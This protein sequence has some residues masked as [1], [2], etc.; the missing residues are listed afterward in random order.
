M[1]QI[2]RAGLCL[3]LLQKHWVEPSTCVDF[4]DSIF[5][6]ETLASPDHCGAM[7][8]LLSR[9]SALMR[10]SVRRVNLNAACASPRRWLSAKAE[11]PG[12]PP[13]AEAP[14]MLFEGPKAKLVRTMKMVSIANLGFAVASTPI[15][16]A[17]T[18]ASGAP[19]KGIAMSALLLLF[20]GGTTGA[21]T[22]ATRTYVKS[23]HSV[24]GSTQLAI[25]TPTFFGADLL[26]QVPLAAVGRVDTY[27]PFA[28]F[29]ADGRIFYLDELGQLDASL[30][31]V[32]EKALNAPSGQ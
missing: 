4:H 3:F 30:Q 1:N 23:I 25:V 21:L 19:G 32:L 13:A 8:A 31:N 26:S 11:V 9:R 15:L 17:V 24:P 16:Y 14:V 18:L 22:W 27:H 28:T 12:Q 6:A 29:S 10:P 7:L 20:G 5:I 2:V